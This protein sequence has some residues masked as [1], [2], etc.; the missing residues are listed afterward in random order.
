MAAPSLSATPAPESWRSSLAEMTP[1]QRA[2]KLAQV[3]D[4]DLAA[5][6]TDWPSWARPEQVAPAGAWTVWLILAGRGWG[7]T[8]TGAEWVRA[9]D[10]SPSSHAPP[11]TP[12]T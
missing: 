6:L 7:K 10:A 5:L 12:A 3:S 2:A 9:R 1:T 4:A 11:L 8:R